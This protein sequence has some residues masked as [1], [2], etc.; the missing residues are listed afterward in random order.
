MCN[1]LPDLVHL[2]TFICSPLNKVFFFTKSLD[3]IKLLCFDDVF[4]TFLGL[5]SRD[6]QRVHQG[7]GLKCKKGAI[8]GKNIYIGQKIGY[9]TILYFCKKSLIVIKPTF[10]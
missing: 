10:I 2:F 3:F 6:V 9:I 1:I 5:D 4:R 7:Q 8:C